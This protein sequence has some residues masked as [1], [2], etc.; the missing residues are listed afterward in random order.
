MSTSP[1]RL[2][3]VIDV[4]NTNTVV[5]I[6]RDDSLVDHFRLSTEPERTDDE[7]ASLMLPLLALHGIEL[8]QADAVVI[9]S[10]VP[11]LSDTLERLSRKFFFCEP[12]FVA[13]GVRTGLV[14]R[15]E[16]PSEVGAD[17][18]ANAVAALELYGA[19]IVVV[20]F[21]TATTFDVLNEAG[22]YVG[23]VI[24]PG[25]AISAEALFSQASRLYRVDVRRPDAVVGRNTATA[26]QSG[27]YFGALG[28]VDGLL[29]RIKAE[30]SGL[31][32][33]IATGGHAALVAE[34]SRHI[35]E[36]DPLLTLYGLKLI[37]ERNR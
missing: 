7:Y 14:I 17:R 29:D 37:D 1:S 6:Y 21:G 22:E 31:E 11:T 24:A 3:I 16:N 19:P 10:V 12:L 35:D 23:G 27:I 25:I 5:G 33:V 2:L 18:I 13:P 26:M 30:I 36:V 20:D 34:G 15:N 4:G 8:G 9:A 32:K 28:L